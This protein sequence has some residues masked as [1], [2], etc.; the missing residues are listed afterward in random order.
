MI[1]PD[2]VYMFWSYILGMVFFCS[3]IY[4]LEWLRDDYK[5]TKESNRRS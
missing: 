5:K 2:V 4:F 1:I 3:L